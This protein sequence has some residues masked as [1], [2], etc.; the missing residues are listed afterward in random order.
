MFQTCPEESSCQGVETREDYSAACS[1]LNADQ[2]PGTPGGSGMP[3]RLLRWSQTVDVRPL[4]HLQAEVLPSPV[5][6]PSYLLRLEAST[7]EVPTTSPQY[8]H[9]SACGHRIHPQPSGDQWGV[10]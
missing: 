7:T 1:A 2:C 8:T 5:H 9:F 6:L 4:V 10:V 3:W